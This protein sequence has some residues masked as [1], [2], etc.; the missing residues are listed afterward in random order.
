M[1]TFINYAVMEKYMPLLLATLATSSIVF[2]FC[3]SL[4]ASASLHG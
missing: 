1:N 3:W 2:G 4:Y